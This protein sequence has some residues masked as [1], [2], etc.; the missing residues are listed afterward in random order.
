MAA[1]KVSSKLK[2]G[3]RDASRRGRATKDSP[4]MAGLRKQTDS[5][6]TGIRKTRKQRDVSNKR[7]AA[8]KTTKQP[9]RSGRSASPMAPEKAPVGQEY[10]PGDPRRGDT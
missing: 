8:R 5:K 10:L 1:K 7:T 3:K 4:E 6:K 9:R 2:Q